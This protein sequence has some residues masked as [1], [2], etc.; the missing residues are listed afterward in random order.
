[1]GTATKVALDGTEVGISAML[2]LEAGAGMSNALA[3]ETAVGSFT[4]LTI[5]TEVGMLILPMLGAAT[6]TF[7][8]PSPEVAPVGIPVEFSG[9]ARQRAFRAAADTRGSTRRG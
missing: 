9:L 6:G 1:M 2:A 4:M 8:P 3:S 5:D 7:T